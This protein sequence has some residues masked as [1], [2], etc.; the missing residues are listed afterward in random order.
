MDVSMLRDGVRSSPS[1]IC[2]I[3]RDAYVRG[4]A[5][6]KQ[7]LPLAFPLIHN[8]QRLVIPHCRAR[9]YLLPSQ[10]LCIEREFIYTIV[11]HDSRPFSRRSSVPEAGGQGRTAQARA[12]SSR[13]DRRR[14]K[15]WGVGQGTSLDSLCSGLSVRPITR[16]HRR[17]KSVLHQLCILLPHYIQVTMGIDILDLIESKGGKPELVKESQRRRNASVELVDECIGLYEA[18]VKGE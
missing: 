17:R 1:Y 4:M 16:T 11:G 15:F 2:C 13:L 14:G 9:S 3:S 10:R 8:P 5:S 6:V 7:P 12:A 18:W